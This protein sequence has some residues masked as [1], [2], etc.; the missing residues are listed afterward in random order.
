[1]VPYI[2]TMH[3]HLNT[4]H[5]PNSPIRKTLY[6]TDCPVLQHIYEIGLFKIPIH[7]SQQMWHICAKQFGYIAFD[8]DHRTSNFF[9]SNFFFY[10]TSFA[11]DHQ[12]PSWITVNLWISAKKLD[13]F[14]P[15]IPEIFKQKFF[16]KLHSYNPT[17]LSYHFFDPLAELKQYARENLHHFCQKEWRTISA[18]FMLQALYQKFHHHPHLKF[19][20]LNTGNKIIVYQHRYTNP[21]SRPTQGGK[22]DDFWGA[23]AI[24]GRGYNVMGNLLCLVR[25]YLTKGQTPPPI[26]IPDIKAF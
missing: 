16:S 12:K 2:N 17:Q 11:T 7:D 3:I 13:Y 22:K 4:Q 8:D 20:L 5:V 19:R 23:H 26:V 14:Y 6:E 1:M 15:P 10:D 21:D 25:E 24:S 18:A 9:L